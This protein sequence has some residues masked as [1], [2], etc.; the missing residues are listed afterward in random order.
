MGDNCHHG[1]ITAFCTMK[2]IFIYKLFCPIY[3]ILNL[4]FFQV[5]FEMQNWCR[6]MTL[7]KICINLDFQ[8]SYLLNWV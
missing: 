8:C 5:V 7:K 4:C 1:L 2:S 3:E 6:L